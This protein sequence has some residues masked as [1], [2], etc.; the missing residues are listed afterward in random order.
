MLL[1]DSLL[2]CVHQAF[3]SI[4]AVLEVLLAFLIM[5]SLGWRWLLGFSSLPVAIF[6]CFS[7]VSIVG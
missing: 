7:V 1:T 4:G 3:W 5:P 6:I 2:V